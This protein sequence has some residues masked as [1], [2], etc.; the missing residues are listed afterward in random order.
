M[1]YIEPSPPAPRNAF[2]TSDAPTLEDV[3]RKLASA[4]DINDRHR[5]ELRSAVRTVGRS[6]D[7]HLSELPANPRFLRERLE[8]VIPVAAGLSDGRWKNVRSLLRKA[9][10]VAGIPVLPGRHL[11]PLTNMWQQRYNNL[12]SRKLRIGLSRFFHYCSAN[13][14]S[15]DKITAATFDKFLDALERESLLA[16]PLT[17]HRDACQCWN[18]AAEQ[19]DGWPKLGIKVPDYRNWYILDWSAFPLSLEADVETML[20]TAQRSDLLVET[21]LP[22]INAVTV[23]DRRTRLR[24]IASAAVLNGI[25][26]EQLKGIA[27]LVE[28]DV[29]EAGFH[30]FLNRSDGRTTVDIH[31][32]AKLLWTLAKHWVGVDGL[33][34]EA[35][36]KFKKRLDPGR[37]GM[38]KKNRDTLRRFNDPDLVQE[39]LRLP[40]KI[41]SRLSLGKTPGLRQAVELQVALAVAILI[42]APIRTKNLASIHLD[43]NLVRTGS[44]T[45]LFFS[46]D[47]VKNDVELEFPLPER[48]QNLLDRYIHEV[49][50]VLLRA[51]SSWLF[52]GESTDH[53]GVG[54]MSS[55]IADL[56]ERELG[57]RLTAHQ[58]RH[59]T[60]YLYLKQNPGGYEVVRRLLGHRTIATTME[61]YTW[62]ET[63]DAVRHFDATILAL[64]D[65]EPAQ[66]HTPRRRKGRKR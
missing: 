41:F 66:N 56:V 46:A 13:D 27:D 52:P 19:V 30:F 37:R 49:R 40:E 55:Q 44:A 53:K 9:L 58:Y 6:L 8:T 31:Q 64:M 26:A 28:P 10:E 54:L 5:A 59:L 14:L 65:E 48:I 33:H 35:L 2:T 11:A 15:P 62:M 60:A 23:R 4:D 18:L 36:A 63:A 51:P 7:R 21:T 17:V 20:D 22:R 39:F 16:D 12:P 3:F 61:F 32:N 42:V 38:T 24:R 43:H 1:T 47:E 29:A 57:V 50:P 45:H 34:L 25:A